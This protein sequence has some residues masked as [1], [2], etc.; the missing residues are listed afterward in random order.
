[1]SQLR[2]SVTPLLSEHAAFSTWLGPMDVPLGRPLLLW[3][4][5]VRFLPAMGKLQGGAARALS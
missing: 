1:M 4:I 5:L 2:E 3:W